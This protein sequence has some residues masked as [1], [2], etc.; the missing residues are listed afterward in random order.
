MKDKGRE[1][2]KSFNRNSSKNT[3]SNTISSGFTSGAWRPGVSFSL[4]IGRYTIGAARGSGVNGVDGTY[5]VGMTV[6][7]R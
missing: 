7:L 1:P 2:A 5:R 3:S 4:R 6:G